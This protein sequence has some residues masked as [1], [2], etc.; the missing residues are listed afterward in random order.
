MSKY[1]REVSSK[2]RGKFSFAAGKVRQ[3]FIRGKSDADEKHIRDKQEK[4]QY[5]VKGR[6]DG[7]VLLWDVFELDGFSQPKLSGT[8][9]AFQEEAIAFARDRSLGRVNIG[10]GKLKGVFRAGKAGVLVP[11]GGIDLPNQ[12]G[13]HVP[14]IKTKAGII[15]G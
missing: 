7:G 15:V 14:L 2:V 11:G 4:K 9:F 6:M 1:A 12:K 10:Y 3:H 13:K 8:G 5:L